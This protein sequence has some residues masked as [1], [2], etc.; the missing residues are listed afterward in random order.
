MHASTATASNT[1]RSLQDVEDEILKKKSVPRAGISSSSDAPQTKYDDSLPPEQ[2]AGGK[3]DVMDHRHQD[4][5]MAGSGETLRDTDLEYGVYGGPGENGLAVAFAVEEDDEDM[6]IPSAVEYDPDAKP[7]MYRNRR[8]RLYAFLA[9][10]VVVVVTVGA[11]IGI[12]LSN[13]RK[14]PEIP[15][16]QTLGIRENIER[17]VG[18][19]VLDDYSTAYS[20]ALDWI[21]NVDPKAVAPDDS[22]FA[23]RFYAACFY[24]A[25]SAE[26]PWS[27]GCNPPVGD[28]P[29]HC[30]YKRLVDTNPIEY[31]TIPWIR[32][33][34][35][36]SECNW[37]G[38][39]CDENG[40]FRT[41]ELS[42]C[43]VSFCAY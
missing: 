25:T 19:D 40:Q 16:R 14:I 36:Q 38:V 8:F 23:Q 21:T 24:F 15:Y 13:Q 2:Y 41:I 6:F 37:A 3:D 11:A 18:S 5:L 9:I 30:Q 1:P 39:G 26:H 42:E 43:L 12:T 10:V 4:G 31:A 32:W 28:E 33:L 27:G 20:K 35:G 34:S 22:S 29:D 7:P 17:L